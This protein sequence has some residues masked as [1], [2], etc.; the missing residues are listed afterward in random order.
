[1]SE[2]TEL[3]MRIAQLSG[4][5]SD[6]NRQAPDVQIPVRL[7]YGE[8]AFR[9]LMLTSGLPLKE[10]STRGHR[11]PSYVRKLAPGRHT[12]PPRHQNRTLVLKKNISA[13]QRDTEPGLT[14]ERTTTADECA[15]ST[16]WVEKN[17]RHRQLIN[18]AVYEKTLQERTT[19]LEETRKLKELHRDD[20]ERA[21]LKSF[22]Y[23]IHG[24]AASK[25]N[26]IPAVHNIDIQ[27]MPFRVTNGGSR[28]LR[29][30]DDLTTGQPTPKFASVGGVNF[31]RSVHGN[32]Y[33]SGVAQTARCVF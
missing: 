28:L 27:G 2:N 13:T 30:P 11:E 26:D 15:T 21:K 31:Y 32:M 18:P 12:L 6:I 22:L 10:Y 29:V 5:H 8:P 9:I 7:H 17:A 25:P 20:R 14:V 24:F 33:R 3:Q 23:G 19:R 16:A 4:V 1:M